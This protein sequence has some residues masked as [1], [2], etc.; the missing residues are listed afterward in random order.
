MSKK[1]K[2]QSKISIFPSKKIRK[3]GKKQEKTSKI[4]ENPSKI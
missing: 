4:L 1:L 3:Q 2:N